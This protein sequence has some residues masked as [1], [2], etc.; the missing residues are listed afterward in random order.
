MTWIVPKNKVD[1]ALKGLDHDA[2]LFIVPG[3]DPYSLVLIRRWLKRARRDG[4]VA[5]VALTRVEAALPEMREWCE[6]NDIDYK[7]SPL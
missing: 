4:L 6:N 5:P 3:D 2:M 7:A 1:E